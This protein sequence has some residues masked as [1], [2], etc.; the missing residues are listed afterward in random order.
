[1]D[2]NELLEQLQQVQ[3]ALAA[4][5]NTSKYTDDVV[6]LRRR[7]FEKLVSVADS[8]I[9]ANRSDM[10]MTSFSAWAELQRIVAFANG[11]PY[12]KMTAPKYVVILKEKGHVH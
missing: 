5:I 1:M 12:G 4:A 8:L 9:E 3:D 11:K 7:D 2:F 6:V 10:P